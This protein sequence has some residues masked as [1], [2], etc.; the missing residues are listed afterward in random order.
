M[1]GRVM[2]F[3]ADPLPE[4]YK[5]IYKRRSTDNGELEDEDDADVYCWY[6]NLKNSSGGTVLHKMVSMKTDDM[7]IFAG[8]AYPDASYRIHNELIVQKIDSKG[9]KQ[10]LN[11]T[12]KMMSARHRRGTEGERNVMYRT[13]NRQ[14]KAA[15]ILENQQTLTEAN[16]SPDVHVTGPL[17]TFSTNANHLIEADMSDL[18]SYPFLKLVSPED[19]LYVSKYFERLIGSTDVMFERFS[20]LYQPH[21]IDGDIV[22]S[23]E[24][25]QR[26]VVECLGSAV[27]DGVVLLLRKLCIAPPPKRDT[28]GNFIRATIAPDSDNGLSLFEL[29]SDDPSTSEAPDRWTLMN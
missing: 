20:L 6:T 10:D 19:V 13:R 23:D 24:D 16:S 22:V 11:V 21:V 5:E 27:A 15:F 9:V 12:Q 28:M 1:T 26:V 4:A 17:I 7:V 3:V 14:A 29:L 18:V 8:T 2:D 25:N